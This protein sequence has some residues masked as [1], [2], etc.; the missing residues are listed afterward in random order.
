MRQMLFALAA[1]ATIIARV[2]AGNEVTAAQVNGTWQYR[3]NEFKILALGQQKL[4]IEF[5]GVYEYK[6]G[7]GERTANTGEGS[8]IAKIEG[9]TATF[10]PDGAEEECK[11]TL[12]FTGGKL[13]V[14]QDGMCGFGFNVR[15][16]GTYKRTSSK[17]PKFDAE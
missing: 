3:N 8:G 14:T 9:D 16:D 12:K 7:N 15:A 5:S 10:K 1:C 13:V 6:T 17:K 2:E 4:Q 11:I